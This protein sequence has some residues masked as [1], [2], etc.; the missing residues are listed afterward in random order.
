[1]L[2]GVLNNLDNYRLLDLTTETFEKVFQ[3]CHPFI[4]LDIN[5]W[6]SC[7]TTISIICNLRG[8]GVVDCLSV[9]ACPLGLHISHLLRFLDIIHLK[10]III[11]ERGLLNMFA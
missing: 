3:L 5:D 7:I 10:L 4:A 1:M 2:V 6:V 9:A 11:Q 8:T